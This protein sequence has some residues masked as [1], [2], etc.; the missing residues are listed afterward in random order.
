[1]GPDDDDW[2][3]WEGREVMRYNSRSVITAA[4]AIL[5]VSGRAGAAL[6]EWAIGLKTGT[7][8]IGGELT[9]DLLPNV[10][11]RGSVQWLDFDF[12]A[13]FD[14]IDYDVDVEFL[15]PL[16]MIDWYPF[17]GGF[18]VSGGILFNGTDISLDATSAAS[19]E[20]GGTT[21]Y[22]D[23]I[24]TLRGESDFDD[25]APYVGI[26]FHN[27]LSRNGHWGFTG[28]V[29]VAF[30]GSPNV[31]LRVTGPYADDPGLQA[32]LAKEEARIEDDLDGIRFYPVL[33]ATLYYRF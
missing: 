33:S 8:G 18:R 26:G 2:F 24:G 3:A 11:L 14:D 28:D 21:Y 7:L 1:M 25:I 20:I 13:E 19:I 12:E 10:N 31:N 23:E 16:L 15:N 4:L 29:G 17:S 6:D 32:D 22:P 30:I 5:A 9:T 27:P